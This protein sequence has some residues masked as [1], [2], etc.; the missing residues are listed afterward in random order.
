[1]RKE[2]MYFILKYIVSPGHIITHFL[3]RNEAIPIQR[4]YKCSYKI[5]NIWES[6]FVNGLPVNM[7]VART[8][9]TKEDSFI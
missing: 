7:N 1:M 2:R 9:V 6:V 3:N 4:Q 5:N 8:L